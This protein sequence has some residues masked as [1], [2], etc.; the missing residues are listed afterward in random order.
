MN[1]LATAFNN[2]KVNTKIA[3]GFAAVLAILI[4]VAGLS[5]KT[6]VALGHEF[7]TYA[8]RVKVVVIARDVDREFLAFRRLV[9]EFSI[10]GHEEDLEKA[11]AIR[12]KLSADIAKGLDEI[13]N[14]ER[15]AKMR[16]IGKDF[17]IYTAS[18]DK[19]APLRRD[20][21]TQIK[22]VL[23]PAGETLYRNINA[24]IES[25][26]GSGNANVVI[27]G[28]EAMQ[29][30]MI[31]RLNANKLLARHEESA[32]EAAE[33]AFRN[34]ATVI[35]QIGK[36]HLAEDARKAYDNVA[37]TTRTYQE[38][39]AGAAE[40]YHEVDTLV[41]GE[42]RKIAEEIATLSSDIKVSGVEEEHKLERE[43]LDLIASSQRSA[44]VLSLAG[45]IGGIVLSWLIGRGI[46]NPIRAVSA[47]LLELA[48]GNKS[49]AVPFTERKDEVGENARAA[50]IFKDN[51]LKIEQM[52]IER[53][54]NER[55]VAEQRKADMHKLADEFQ[56]AVGGIVDTVSSASAQLEVAAGSLART[57]ETTQSLSGSVAS[58]SE[59]TSTNVQGVAAASEQLSSTVQEISRQVQESSIIASQA[60]HQASKTNDCV[61]ELSHS[62]DR[63]G[64]VIG[65]INTIA[66]QTNLLALNATIEA[67]RAGDAGKGF[68]V[69][70]QEVKALAAQTA[71]AT[72]E[73]SSQISDMQTATG[74]A[75]GAI[76]DITG[77]IN[78]M[79]EIAGAIASAV[80]QQGA[81][82][83]EISRNVLEAAKG[84][85][86][87]ATSIT[88]VSKGAFETGSASSQV[89][90]SAKQLS[91]ESGSLR[92]AVRSF[93]ATVRAA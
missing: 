3:A 90:S 12:H 62:A 9:R 68:A 8:Q 63:I 47:V 14:P 70:A 55:R 16:A 71:K 25:G 11:N 1:A 67:A 32:K 23:D 56:R 17:E 48:N 81:T 83:K 27:L 31:A 75:V 34:L 51:L 24:M 86:E 92:D 13:K 35:A 4:V 58:A 19:L 84:T 79:S 89:L 77:T 73:I 15:L 80:E 74:E 52:E 33:G 18:L 28:N 76:K 20:Q 72:N 37:A 65:L 42:M 59:Q 93:L 7:E 66:G 39:F 30:L 61:S 88:D 5:L 69:V 2:L 21:K 38:A 29:H 45:L 50:R 43:T 22:D 91:S 53:R 54:D 49:V 46:A 10:N 44:L 82:T 78:R 36:L 57:A 40:D 85:S 60:V 41:N 6:L 26:A 64:D 87:V